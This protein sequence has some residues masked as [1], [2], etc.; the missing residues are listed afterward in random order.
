LKHNHLFGWKRWEV[1]KI[2]MNVNGSGVAFNDYYSV[3]LIIEPHRFPITKYIIPKLLGNGIVNIK[4]IRNFV[5]DKGI[6][7]NK[8]NRGAR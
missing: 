1:L 8:K 7:F 4:A 3:V 6:L 5:Y 2:H